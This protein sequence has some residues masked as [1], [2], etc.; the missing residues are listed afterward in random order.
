MKG[1]ATTGFRKRNVRSGRRLFRHL[2]L[3]RQCQG[4]WDET[5]ASQSDLENKADTGVLDTR[6]LATGVNWGP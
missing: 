1:G 2:P 4:T 6:A 5:A 3:V